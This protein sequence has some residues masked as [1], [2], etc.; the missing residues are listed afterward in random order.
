MSALKIWTGGQE[1]SPQSTAKRCEKGGKLLLF[2]HWYR[3]WWPWMTLNG[4]MTAI[5][6]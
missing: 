3:I 1:T 5:L 2:T 4:V 6:R